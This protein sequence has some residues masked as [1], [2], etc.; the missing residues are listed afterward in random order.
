MRVVVDKES[1]MKMKIGNVDITKQVFILAEIGSNHNGNFETATQLVEAA[2]QSGADGVKFQT[3]EP[4]YLVHKDLPVAALARGVHKTQVERLQSIKLNDEQHKQLKLLADKFEL[5][6]ISTPFDERSVEFLDNL[7]PAF[8]VSSGDLT[9]IPLLNRIKMKEK[10]L[11]RMAL[12]QHFFMDRI[13]LYAIVNESVALAKKFCHESFVRF[14]N[15]LLRKISKTQLSLPQGDNVEDLGV[16][17]SYPDFFVEHNQHL[18]V[19]Y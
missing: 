6:F 14:F 11:L 9:N 4:E 16:H 18:A 15:M 13:P 3:F 1:S 10:V 5:E 8:K 2:A 12:Y 7:V 17:Y 19:T